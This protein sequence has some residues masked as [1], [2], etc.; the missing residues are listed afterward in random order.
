MKLVDIGFG[1]M[2]SANSIL[3]ILNPDATPVKRIVHVAKEKSNLIDATCGRKT[4]SV[5]IMDSGHVVASSMDS[6]KICG[7]LKEE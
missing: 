6:G 7:E 1:H 3:S 2:L 4:K 5:I